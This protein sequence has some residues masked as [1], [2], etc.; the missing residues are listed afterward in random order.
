MLRKKLGKQKQAGLKEKGGHRAG[1]NSRSH[2]VRKEISG[3][4]SSEFV[5]RSQR[6][7][8]DEG[9]DEWI[10]RNLTNEGGPNLLHSSFWMVR[11]PTVTAAL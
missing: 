8:K 3:R 6:A 4:K 1:S 10:D 9:K 11:F 2:M 7:E 5:S